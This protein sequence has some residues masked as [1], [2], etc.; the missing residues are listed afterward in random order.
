MIGTEGVTCEGIAHH[1]GH[2]TITLYQLN[3]CKGDEEQHTYIH[4]T[5]DM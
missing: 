3:T 2:Y 4:V 1:H 5:C